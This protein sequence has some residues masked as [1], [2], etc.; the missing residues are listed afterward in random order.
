MPDHFEPRGHVLKHFRHIFTELTQFRTAGRTAIV[1][2]LVQLDL[3]GKM[4]R[5]RATCW[6]AGCSGK[7]GC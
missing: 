7:D 4:I 6:L 1:F 2:R 3:T 5:Q